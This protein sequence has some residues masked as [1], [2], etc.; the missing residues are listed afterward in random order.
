MSIRGMDERLRKVET[1]LTEL[2]ARQSPKTPW[3]VVVGGV[4]GIGSII[5]T[6]VAVL[7]IVVKAIP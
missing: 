4:A 5:I 6:A 1:D 7:T 2:K 3:Y